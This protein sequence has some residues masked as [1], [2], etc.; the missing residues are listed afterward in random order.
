M[1]IICTLELCH[2]LIMSTGL[3]KKNRKFFKK[4]KYKERKSTC[5]LHIKSPEVCEPDVFALI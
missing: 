2:F 4:E 5:W 3:W 1:G